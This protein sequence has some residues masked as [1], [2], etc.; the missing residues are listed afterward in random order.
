MS[1][2]AEAT[3][4]AALQNLTVA[5]QEVRG[6]WRD[7]KCAEFEERYLRELPSRTTQ[8]TTVMSEIEKILKRAK[9]DCG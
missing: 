6:Y 7:A 9:N 2:E 8:A 5:W 3:L 4:A 1:S